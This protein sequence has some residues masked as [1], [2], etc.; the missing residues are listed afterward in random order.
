MCSPRPVA[1]REPGGRGTGAAVSGSATA[2]S[3]QGLSCSRPSRIGRRCGASRCP[4]RACR[5]ALVTSSD[6][7]TTISWLRST[8]PH[9][10]KVATVKSRA[11]RTDPAPAP[12]AHVAIR[13]KRAH[14]TGPG[15]GDTN[16]LPLARPAISAASI[17][18]RRPVPSARCNGCAAVAIRSLLSR[19]GSQ[20]R[21][22]ACRH[23][24]WRLRRHLGSSAALSDSRGCRAA[25]PSRKRARPHPRSRSGKG[26]ADWRSSPRLADRHGR[27][28]RALRVLALPSWPPPG[29]RPRRLGGRDHRCHTQA[30]LPTVPSPGTAAARAA[31]AMAMYRSHGTTGLGAQNP[32]SVC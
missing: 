15:S 27:S 5:S 25:C 1:P 8:T 31:L 26:G 13:G 19:P 3:T 22:P 20:G 21:A 6:T 28:G 17:S 9:R 18:Q 29:R 23:P 16:R 2:H 24:P 11:A 30:P 14:P 10:C 7:T 12:G 4:G 32:E